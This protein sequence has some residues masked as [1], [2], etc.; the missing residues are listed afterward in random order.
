[1]TEHILT[2]HVTDDRKQMWIDCKCGWRYAKMP[3]DADD[4]K[5]VEVA[6]VK[7]GHGH[8]AEVSKA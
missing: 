3:F 6:L 2:V 5:K 4:A 7:I 8:L 1:V